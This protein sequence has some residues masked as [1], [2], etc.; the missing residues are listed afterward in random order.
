MPTFIALPQ[1]RPGGTDVLLGEAIL[2]RTVGFLLQVKPRV[3]NQNKR[4]KTG[5][6]WQGLTF[7]GQLMGTAGPDERGL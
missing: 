1:A 2:R 6:R 5:F 3:Q 4:C 7:G